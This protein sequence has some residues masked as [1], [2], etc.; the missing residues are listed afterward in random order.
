MKSYNILICSPT[1]RLGYVCTV[2]VLNISC[3]ITLVTYQKFACKPRKYHSTILS[4]LMYSIILRIS[5]FNNL[6]HY[7]LIFYIYCRYDQESERDAE[8]CVTKVLEH[9]TEQ[10]VKK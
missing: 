3:F 4:R 1:L 10:F 9:I 2:L 7:S 5:A 8:E 6:I